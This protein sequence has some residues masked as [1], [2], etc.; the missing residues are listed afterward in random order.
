MFCVLGHF[1]SSICF[2]FE[3]EIWG[4]G[5]VVFV[6]VFPVIATAVQSA[7]PPEFVTFALK[8]QVNKLCQL[9]YLEIRRVG[10][11]RQYL[12]IE[13]SRAFFPCLVLSMLDYCSAL[14]VGSPR[15]LLEKKK[16]GG[17]QRSE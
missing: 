1:L 12:S 5:G 10:L 11:I 4:G 9:T 8:E 15:V 13:A 3:R 6:V 2:L 7:F 14:L 16:S 17:K